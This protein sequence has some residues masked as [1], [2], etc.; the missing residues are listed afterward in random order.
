VNGINLGGYLVGEYGSGK[1]LKQGFLR[2]PDGTTVSLE[3]PGAN[4]ISST[5][6]A[7]GINQTGVIVGHYQ[8]NTTRIPWSTGSWSLE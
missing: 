5:T 7:T 3:Y 6:D 2:R 8:I 4:H 1:S